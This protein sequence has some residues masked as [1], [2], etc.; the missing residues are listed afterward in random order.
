MPIHFQTGEPEA[1]EILPGQAG[2]ANYRALWEKS[3]D[4]W[5]GS[6]AEWF[7]HIFH[8]DRLNEYY[9]EQL[10][11]FKMQLLLCR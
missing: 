5:H 8:K 1:I 6:G 4:T 7:P 11:Q 10:L 9:F 3:G 2:R